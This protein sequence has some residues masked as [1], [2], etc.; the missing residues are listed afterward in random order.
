[1]ENKNR[2]T[3]FMFLMAFLVA[4]LIVSFV[5]VLKSSFLPS[6]APEI[7]TAS[8]VST[9]VMPGSFSDLA[10]RVKPAVV[11]ISTTKIFKGRGG[12]ISPF[13]LSPFGSPFGD[14]FFE[15]FFGDI[16]Q[17]EF[18]QRSLGS[19][20]IIS[21]DGYIF[22][23]NH[24]VEQTDKILV[25]ISDGKEYEA[26][27]IGTDAKTD[28]A[29]IKIKPKNNLSFVEIG[30][31]DTLRVGEWVIA[32]G[33]PFGLEQT[34]TAGIVSA[35]GRVIG[36]GLYDDF[37]QTDASIN[38]GNSGGPLFNMAGKVIGIN[39]AIVAQGQGIGFAIP[40]NMAK[41][42]LDDLKTKGK[43][44]RGWLGISIQNITDDIAKNLNHKNK[45]GALVSDVF[46][47]DPADKAGIKV[48]DIITE[49][50]GKPIKNT[51]ELLLTIASLH[52]GEKAIIKAIRDGKV[53]SFQVTVAERTDKA[54]TALA[55]KSAGEYFG[56]S[57]QEISKDIA[58]QL[59]I[60]QN[61]GVIV[62]DVEEGSPADD[63]GI[64]PHDIIAQVNKTKVTSIKQYNAEMSKAAQKKG[65][66]LLVKRGKS[67]FFV[68]LHME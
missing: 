26:K 50:N 19:G 8:A 56:I 27:I 22:T 49:I 59:G 14:D 36:A 38:P 28:I 15:R 29:L 61:S 60:P 53:L 42:I 23:N 12:S 67:N 68:G 7:Q 1:M 9:D 64:Q 34:V 52:V 66:M 6:G 51:H 54:E 63:V 24:V 21:S 41:S 4:F 43:V 46:K 58:K 11:N 55:K 13:D 16:P 20:F 65:V 30:D 5:E 17:R 39:T 47:G 25:K 62:T 40:I 3:F 18:K 48:G 45:N 35:K 2:K 37:I 44:T 33:N 31:S 32:I 57:V 10:E